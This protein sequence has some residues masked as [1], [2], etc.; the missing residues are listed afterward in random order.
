MAARAATLAASRPTA[1]PAAP[2]PQ[3]LKCAAKHEY[4]GVSTSTGNRIY[5]DI[6]G[7][8]RR[9]AAGE[10]AVDV[11]PWVFVKYVPS[12][13]EAKWMANI[14]KWE[15]DICKWSIGKSQDADWEAWIQG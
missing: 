13:L 2:T 11:D 10:S 7:K 6:W 4:R 12:D 1:P 5:P 9:A 8:K 3:P 15:E 14:D